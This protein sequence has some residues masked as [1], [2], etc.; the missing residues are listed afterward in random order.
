MTFIKT[1]SFE[2]L[3]NSFNLANGKPTFPHHNIIR[4]KDGFIVQMA[5]AGF[6]EEDLDIEL[7]DGILNIMGKIEDR[8]PSI[9]YIYHGIATRS[10]H[11]TIQLGANIRVSGAELKHG[12]LWIEMIQVIPDEKKPIKIPIGKVT[13]T[14]EF[15][16][17]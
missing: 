10:F 17:E 4:T 12:I 7:K 6:S 5:L 3:I 16:V 11:K 1:H 8:D 2:D 9:D 13:K 15:L 14:S